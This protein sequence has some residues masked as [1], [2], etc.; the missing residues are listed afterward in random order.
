M[1]RTRSL[2][3]LIPLLAV[4][5]GS[6][7]KQRSSPAPA[8]SEPEDETPSSGCIAASFKDV[9][10]AK[11]KRTRLD[12]YLPDKPREQPMPW[13]VWVHGGGWAGGSRNSVETFAIRQT[14]R[15]YAVVAVDYRLSFEARFPAALSDLRAA[16]RYVR[17]HATEFNLD[18]ENV[19]VWGASAGGHLASMLALTSQEK[20][21]DRKDDRHRQ[22]PITVRGV[23]GWWTPTSFPEFDEDFGLKCLQR[24]C[25]TCEG[26]AE[27]R[28]L[29][30][31]VKKCTQRAR[32]ASPISWVNKHAPPFLLS[33]GSQDCT[34]PEAQSTRLADALKAVGAN[35]Q[36]Q[37]VP[38]GRHG[39]GTWLKPEVMASVDQ[40]IDHHLQ[41]RALSG[42]PAEAP[43]APRVPFVQPPRAVKPRNL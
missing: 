25:H 1:F 36:L 15:G 29:G 2:S 9:A 26:S 10:Y 43:A 22:V 33:H 32:R 6:G 17:A 35:V 30:C 24:T 8:A 34:V 42:L 12:V 16:L 21:F 41:A 18:P 37:I 31:E 40:F 14:C 11:D 4:L 28:F 7:C 23:I 39:D 5:A 19:I 13:V 27:S 38:N 20:S 3:L